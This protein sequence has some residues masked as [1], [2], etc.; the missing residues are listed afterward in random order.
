MARTVCNKGIGPGE[1]SQGG[2]GLTL[3][4]SSCHVQEEG[5]GGTNFFLATLQSTVLLQVTL[6]L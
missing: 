5:S 1:G 2:E 3:V 6:S 4:K